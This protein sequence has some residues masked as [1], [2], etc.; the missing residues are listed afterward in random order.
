M[1]VHCSPLAVDRL[2]A[3]MD[4]EGIAR[5]VNLSGGPPGG[6]LEPQLLASHAAGKRIAVYTSPP[7]VEALRPDYG[8]RLVAALRQAASLGARGL[9]ISKGLGLGVRGPTGELLRID[10]P[11]LDGLFDAA[12]ELQLPVMIHSG[13]PLAFWRPTDPSNERH[14]ELSAHPGWSL[15]GRQVPSFDELYSQ[16]EARV[17][18]HPKTTFVSVHFGNCAEEPERVANSLRAHPNLFIDTAARVP[19]LGRHPVDKVRGFFEEFQDR[20]LFGSDLGVGP[21]PSP[22]FLG[23]SGPAPPTDEEYRLFF[24]ATRRFFETTAEHMPHPTPIQGDWRIDGIELPPQIL[25]KL[26]VS[27]AERVLRL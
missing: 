4:T 17:A 12:G 5:A 8:S 3:I 10:E 16:L 2:L 23:S 13:D 26:Y 25:E 21:H 9:K 11:E 22:L 6:S 18:R 19:E 24:D 15:H 1:H 7:W 14:A 27:N 20:I